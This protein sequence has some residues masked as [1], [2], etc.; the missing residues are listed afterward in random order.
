MV[1]FGKIWASIKRELEFFTP[2]SMR[3]ELERHNGA[4]C[5][6]VLLADVKHPDHYFYLQ[7]GIPIKG[8]CDLELILKEIP[9]ETFAFHVKEGKN[10]FSDWVKNVIGDTTLASKMQKLSAQEEMAKAVSIRV[11][12]IKKRAEQR[13]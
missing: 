12:Y 2:N 6:A 3:Y 11:E 13:F 1:D 5:A 10:D 7:D 4:E 9:A 8:L